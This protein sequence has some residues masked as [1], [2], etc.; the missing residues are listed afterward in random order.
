MPHATQLI[1]NPM[2][3]RG[4]SGQRASDLR[5]M[6]AEGKEAVASGRPV[7]IFPEGTRVRRG[8]KPPLRPGFAGLYR[9][10]GLPVVPVAIDSGRPLKRVTTTGL[11][12]P[13]I[14]FTSSS[15][16]P[17]RTRLVRSPI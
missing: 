16:R 4:R 2:A 17:G 14:A 8:E 12:V 15:C 9:A 5:A 3:D 7:I 10:I 6:V 13:N 1:F 11:P